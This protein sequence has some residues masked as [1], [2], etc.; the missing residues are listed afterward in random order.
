MELLNAMLK[1]LAGIEINI[2]LTQMVL[3]FMH[4][5]KLIIVHIQCLY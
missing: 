3:E 4:R 2:K 5:I 1:S